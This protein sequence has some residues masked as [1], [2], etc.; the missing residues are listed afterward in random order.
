MKPSPTERSDKSHRLVWI[1]VTKEQANE[2]DSIAG[3]WELTRAS[4]CRLIVS[5]FLRN[6]ESSLTV[7]KDISN[8]THTK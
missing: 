1:K 6:P 7:R 5:S 4:L 3:Q 8:L 2:L